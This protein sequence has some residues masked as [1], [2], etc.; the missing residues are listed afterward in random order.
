M[1]RLLLPSCLLIFFL[2]PTLAG[3][4]TALSIHIIEIERTRVIRAADS[5]LDEGPKTITAFPGQRSAGGIHDFY[6]EGDYWWPNPE[7]PDGPYVRKDGLT[8]PDNFI[9]HRQLLW[10]LSVQVPALVAAY[11]ITSDEQYC[12]KALEHLR[13]WFIVDTT[14]MNP[15]LLYAQ[16]IKGRTTGRGIGIIDTIHLV[17]VARA[18][19]VLE[20]LQ[21]I[22]FGDLATIKYWFSQYLHWLTTHEYGLAERDNGNNHS[23]CWTLQVAAFADL[24]GDQEQ[25]DFCRNFYRASLLPQQMA[26]DGSFPK[27]LQRTKPYGYSLFNL[28]AM[29]TLC[30]ILS[31]SEEDLWK[32]QMEDGRCMARAM[33]FMVPYIRDKSQ[34]PYPPDVMYFDQWPVRHPALLFAGLA[35]GNSD[36]IT[37]WKLLDPDP[38]N[39]EVL[40]NYPIRQP[41]LWLD[42][43]EDN[44]E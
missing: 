20:T 24:V 4:Q 1:I 12:D 11:K 14:R 18:I 44:N 33:E 42:T 43:I 27:E 19:A 41:L 36:Y 40:R 8:N 29:A 39:E 9:I 28:D 31:K 2:L 6:S 17:E 38:T 34:W 5:Y 23:T 21:A 22:P 16:A 10:R 30:H 26:V 15:N 35:Y 13:A 25:L 3:E 7:D 32:Y 37:L